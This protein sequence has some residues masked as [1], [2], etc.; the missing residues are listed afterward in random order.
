MR[1]VRRGRT[2][3]VRCF[4]LGGSNTHARLH[5]CPWDGRFYSLSGELQEAVESETQ[6]EELKR[7]EGAL[8]EAVSAYAVLYYG[9]EALTSAFVQLH[10]KQLFVTV[11]I[12]KTTEMDGADADASS[13]GHG[14]WDSIHVFE[15]G[16]S[17][18]ET[19]HVYRLTTSVLLSFANSTETLQNITL[20][21]SLMRQVCE[22]GCY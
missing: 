13:K 12:K 20:A 4:L 7:L 22:W 2:L 9:S 14:S 18:E 16:E 19:E 10:E 8:N 5:S 15:I 1:V 21:G 17:D 11:L 6:S 3:S